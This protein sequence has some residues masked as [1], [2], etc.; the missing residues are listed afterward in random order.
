MYVERFQIILKSGQCN[1][2]NG[3]FPL[4]VRTA[5]QDCEGPVPNPLLNLI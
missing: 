4:V 5:N 1:V 2:W 3:E